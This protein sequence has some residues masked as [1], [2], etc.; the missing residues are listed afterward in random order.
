LVK[1][2]PAAATKAAKPPPAI[3]TEEVF[4][5]LLFVETSI[6]GSI[7]QTFDFPSW[8]IET[9]R[10]AAG[11]SSSSAKTTV[12]DTTGLAAIIGAVNAARKAKILVKRSIS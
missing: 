12:L 4:S 10:S 1:I 9:P 5:S 6:F 2:T 11:P 7:A 3:K 8:S